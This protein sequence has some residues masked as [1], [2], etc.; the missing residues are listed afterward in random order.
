MTKVS[1][2][3][4]WNHFLVIR[5]NLKKLILKGL[6]NFTVNHEKRINKYLKSLKLSGALGVEQH[7][8]IKVT[9]SRPG[10]SYGLCKV[11]FILLDSFFYLL[12]RRQI[13]FRNF[14]FPE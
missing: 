1:I 14:W 7:K 13:K 2:L 6:L 4:I 5:L 3:N 11:H 10:V 9:G 8:K 12:E